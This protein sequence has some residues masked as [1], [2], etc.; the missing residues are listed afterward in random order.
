MR[1]PGKH[2]QREFENSPLLSGLA[3]VKQPDVAELNRLR[4][5]LVAHTLPQLRLK[6][7]LVTL[8]QCNIL[9]TTILCTQKWQIGYIVIVTSVA[10]ARVFFPFQGSHSRTVRSAYRL[11][12]L[13]T[14][15]YVLK[16]KKTYQPSLSPSPN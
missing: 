16:K 9:T 7:A 8:Q 5:L 14:K 6:L 11:K 10:K 2:S 3:K 4:S 1:C 12:S 13:N 15:Y